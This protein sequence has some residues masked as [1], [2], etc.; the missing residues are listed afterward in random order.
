MW[1]IIVNP[2]AGNGKGRKNWPAIKD[3]LQKAGITYEYAFTEYA[4]HATELAT[5]AIGNGFKKIITVGGD[6]TNNEVINGI[7]NQHK[8]PTHQ[9]TLAVIPIGTGNDWI[10]HHQIPNDIREAVALIVIENTT[11]HDVGLVKYSDGKQPRLRYFI[12]VAGMAYDAY[13]A[14]L[15]QDKRSLLKNQF[16]YLWLILKGL[17][18]YKLQKAT[19]E[20][21]G[22][23]VKDKFYT[24]N[25]GICKYNGG[26]MQFVPHAE[27]DDGL[28]AL[29]YA[30]HIPK[31][32]IILLT[33]RFYNG[34]IPS[35]RQVRTHQVKSVK[36]T[37]LDDTPTLLEVD[38]EF[39][40][41]TP[42]EFS[43]I[44]K[45]L[46]VVVP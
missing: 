16:S 33:H 36:V 39:I 7:F 5:A 26:G 12:N 28:L 32:E 45:A 43:I 18:K 29:T 40:G 41:H 9:I 10:R 22:Q 37:S 15:T 11:P 17:F 25:V 4:K 46:R 30:F 14:R 21:D 44:E 42:I 1:Y 34:T 13:I 24:I 35:H 3:A 8:V 2:E 20:F 6:G 31:L 38:G 19:I 23:V 27:S